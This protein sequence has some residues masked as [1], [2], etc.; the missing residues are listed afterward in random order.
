MLTNLLWAIGLRTAQ[1]AIESTPTLLCGLLVAGAMRK[2]LGPAGT[3]RLFGGSGW[4]GLWRAW[5]AGTILPVCS[6]GVIPIAREKSRAN[7]GETIFRI[8]VD[9]GAGTPQT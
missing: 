6:L 7:L 2:M 3:R 8:F 4:S 1:A 5:V 9:A